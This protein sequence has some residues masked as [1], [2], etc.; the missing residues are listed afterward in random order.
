M[1]SG[2][3]DKEVSDLLKKIFTPLLLCM[4]TFG[5]LISIKIFCQP[6]MKKYTTFR[7]LTLL[8]I[9]DLCTLYTGCG[10][11]FFDVFFGIDVR[12]IN[13]FT[14][15]I[16]SFLVYFF[17]HFSSILL[18]GNFKTKTHHLNLIAYI[19]FFFLKIAMSI[20]R[21]VSIL[22]R[23]ANKR[24]TPRSA[25]RIFFILGFI[26]AL[27]NIHFIFF[28]RLVENILPEDDEDK[29]PINRTFKIVRFCYA[30]PNSLYFSYVSIIFPWLKF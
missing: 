24:S 21:T 13:D 25:M 10:Q 15:K 6:N 7:Y 20:D 26:I 29:I 4:G 16:Q 9:V 12:S 19:R 11:I 28:T 3:E 22:S 2:L 8:S 27:L 17:T 5:N 1:N 30:P 23:R 18:A 14:C